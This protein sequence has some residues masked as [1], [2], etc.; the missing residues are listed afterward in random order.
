MAD[1]I[2]IVTLLIMIVFLFTSNRKHKAENE[3]VLKAVEQH[4][5]NEKTLLENNEKILQQIKFLDKETVR[6]RRSIDSLKREVVDVA[7]GYAKIN[8]RYNKM[9]SNELKKKIDTVIPDLSVAGNQSTNG[10]SS[11]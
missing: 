3:V 8:G 1:I 2:V 9:N 4:K 7:S 5:K 6:M 10:S 11:N